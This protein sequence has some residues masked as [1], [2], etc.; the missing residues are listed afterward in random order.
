MGFF[1]SGR[2][3]GSLPQSIFWRIT[4]VAILSVVLSALGLL[5]GTAQANEVRERETRALYVQAAPLATQSPDERER[6]AR[7]LY[8]EAG[9]LTKSGSCIASNSAIDSMS[10]L[11]GAEAVALME[12]TGIITTS[13]NESS[14]K[15]YMACLERRRKA[16]VI[17]QRITTDFGDT[18]VAFELAK[19]D[20]STPK[21]IEKIIAKARFSRKNTGRS[22]IHSGSSS[23]ERREKRMEERREM[24]KLIRS[25][26]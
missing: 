16:A 18:Q 9:K 17:H 11:L 8:V 26:Q 3:F 22:Q 4:A 5:S 15:S 10:L 6:E 20:A 24:D 23:Q 7:L 2:T 12:R 21:E 25:H 19:N 1:L 14:Y 13:M